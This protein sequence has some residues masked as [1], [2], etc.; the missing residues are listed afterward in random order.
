MRTPKPIRIPKT[1][2]S[3]QKVKQAETGPPEAAPSP[4]FPGCQPAQENRARGKP[5][6]S[7]SAPQRRYLIRRAATIRWRAR[8]HDEV[9]HAFKLEDDA[10]VLRSVMPDSNA[11]RSDRAKLRHDVPIVRAHHAAS[12]P[13][14]SRARR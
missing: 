5:L 4:P 9:R 3:I 10:R 2:S 12:G 14:K 7:E 8:N 11:S 6:G 13:G 1:L